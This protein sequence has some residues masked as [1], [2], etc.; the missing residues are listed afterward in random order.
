MKLAEALSNR[1]DLQ[2]RINMLNGRLRKSCTVKESSTPP[3]DVKELLKELDVCLK[4][5]QKLV[6]RINVTNLSTTVEGRNLTEVMAERDAL[7]QRVK[8][9]HDVVK[10]LMEGGQDR[11][12]SEDKTIRLLDVPEFRKEMDA[13]SKQLRQLDLKLQQANWTI[14][15]VEV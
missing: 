9:Y 14:D 6:Y 13:Y 5:F 2:K 15:L 4:Q 7:Q 1:S 12:S 11:W 10:T 8:I 3:E